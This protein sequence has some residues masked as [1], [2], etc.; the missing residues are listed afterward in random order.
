MIP[1]PYLTRQPG[2]LIRASDWNEVQRRFREE[3]AAHDHTGGERGLRLTGDSF[4]P[5]TTLKV[6]E[7]H[8][9][10]TLRL[11]G[12]EIRPPSEDRLDASTLKNLT[13]DG[14]L[15]VSGEA[16]WTPRAPLRTAAGRVSFE[17][18]ES[19]PVKGLNLDLGLELVRPWQTVVVQVMLRGV[20]RPSWK[21]STDQSSL[22]LEPRCVA[23][24]HDV[25]PFLHAN[26]REFSVR[27]R[28]TSAPEPFQQA[29]ILVSVC[30]H[31]CRLRLSTHGAWKVGLLIARAF[32]LWGGGHVGP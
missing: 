26:G 3:L 9:T 10:G 14:D 7:I 24:R 22:T 28:H 30:E 12:E 16:R 20:S 2:D 27:Q 5:Q 13:V 18:I 31:G 19:D 1:R 4:D 23:G 15:H 11:A 17:N 32:P 8:V 25:G 6:R 29:E 21:A